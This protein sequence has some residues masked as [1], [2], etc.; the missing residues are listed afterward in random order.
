MP[1]N[2]FL[3]CLDQDLLSSLVFTLS[4]ISSQISAMPA[5][6]IQVDIKESVDC[7]VHQDILNKIDELFDVESLAFDQ[8]LISH[9]LSSSFPAFQKERSTLN[10]ADTS[11]VITKS[12]KEKF[13]MFVQLVTQCFHLAIRL[14]QDRVVPMPRIG[15]RHSGFIDTTGRNQ[16][17]AAD[18]A[19][20]LQ[21]QRIEDTYILVL[22]KVFEGMRKD[23]CFSQGLRVFVLAV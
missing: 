21:R 16:R 19:Q 11:A 1:Q 22:A 6:S 4:V 14:K 12:E 17:D 5:G 3:S 10:R 2:F 15:S 18:R 9:E 8:N 7:L 20:A 23:Q 13:E